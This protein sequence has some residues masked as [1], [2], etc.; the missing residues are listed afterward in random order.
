MEARV[1]ERD[2]EH[3]DEDEEDV[4]AGGGAVGAGARWSYR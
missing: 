2:A 3:A 1:A 4:L